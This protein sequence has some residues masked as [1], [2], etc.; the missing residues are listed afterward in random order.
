[1]KRSKLADSEMWWNG[2]SFLK[3]PEH[4]WPRAE[5]FPANNMTEAEVIK[6]PVATTHVL[7]STSGTSG[8]KVCLMNLLIVLSL[9]VLT[10]C[11]V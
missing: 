8:T 10:S 6:N 4:Q 5:V 2:P 3:S 11:F 7:V 9:A 1:M